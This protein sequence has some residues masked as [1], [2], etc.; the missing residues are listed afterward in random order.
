MSTVVLSRQFA[1]RPVSS[2][3]RGFAIVNDPIPDLEAVFGPLPD[4]P[5]SPS[6]AGFRAGDEL[7]KNQIRMATVIGTILRI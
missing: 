6:L 2:R 1:R 3:E 5:V 7:A 4:E